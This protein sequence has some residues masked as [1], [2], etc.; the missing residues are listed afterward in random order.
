M[1]ITLNLLQKNDAEKLFEFEVDNQLFFEEMVQSRGEDYYTWE[2]FRDRHQELLK[3]QESGCSRFYLVKDSEGNI[4]GRVNLVDIDPT[5]SSAE[6]GFRIGMIHAGKGIGR[7]ALHMLLTEESTLE[8]IYAKTTTVNIAS[9]K[10]LKKNG[11]IQQGISD[12]KFEM[13]GQKMKF[14][15]YSW[16]KSDHG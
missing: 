15:H 2:I 5:A 11:F 1:K 3:E 8:K 16:E 12:E 13:N 7:R 4:V 14:I 9:Q 10:V 6:L